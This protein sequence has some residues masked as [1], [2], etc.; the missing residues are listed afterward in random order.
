MFKINLI[1]Y[2][3]LFIFDEKLIINDSVRSDWKNWICIKII[4]KL[5]VNWTD[6]I[7]T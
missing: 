5:Y 1:S 7:N 6:S 2:K 4:L 3:C